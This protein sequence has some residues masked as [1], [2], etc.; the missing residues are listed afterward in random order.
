LC[1][2]ADV[3]FVLNDH[4]ALAAELGIAAVHLGQDDMFM[5]H[6]RALA[7]RARF[8]LSTH[9]LEQAQAAEQLGADLIGFGPVF[10][11]AS[12]ARPDPVVGLAALREVV[13]HTGI[14]VVAIGGIELNNIDSVVA[15]GAPLVACIGALCKASDPRA[16]AAA[17]H[18]QVVAHRR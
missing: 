17:L 8:G 16:A 5:S 12:K 9:S 4:V 10:Q 14:P 11:T 6:A 15:T 2:R 1:G 3:P 18:A 13:R 7:P